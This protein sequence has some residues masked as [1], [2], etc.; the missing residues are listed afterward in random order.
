MKINIWDTAGEEMYR[1]MT[2]S[3]FRSASAGASPPSLC[4][5]HVYFS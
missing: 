3:F 5:C 2:K 4:H 1:S